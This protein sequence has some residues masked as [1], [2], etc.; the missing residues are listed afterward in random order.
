MTQAMIS[1]TPVNFRT[2]QQEYRKSTIA[3]VAEQAPCCN[4][5]KELSAW[6]LKNNIELESK[7]FFRLCDLM[8][9]DTSSPKVKSTL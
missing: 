5:M 7:E 4:N 8:G 2:W 6:L 1:A 3:S 9:I